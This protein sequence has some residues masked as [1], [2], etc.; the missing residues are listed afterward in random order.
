MQRNHYEQNLYHVGRP[1]ETGARERADYIT[2]QDWVALYLQDALREYA[3]YGGARRK[4]KEICWALVEYID[5]VVREEES[6]TV[7]IFLHTTTAKNTVR[8]AIHMTTYG[9]EPIK[10]NVQDTMDRKFPAEQ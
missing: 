7:T 10:K 5:M 6:I 2:V 3:S 8:N 9:E 4:S 1:E